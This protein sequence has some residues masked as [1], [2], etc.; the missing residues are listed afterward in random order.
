LL[1]GEDLV[2]DVLANDQ[3]VRFEKKQ[4]K[5]TTSSSKTLTTAA[6]V[7]KAEADAQTVE[8]KKDEPKKGK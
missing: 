1:D 5:N 8:T 4:V 3:L 2:G 6:A 7:S